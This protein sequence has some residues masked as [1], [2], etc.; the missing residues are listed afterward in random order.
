MKL[1]SFQKSAVRTVRSTMTRFISIALIS[2]LG[3]GVF[4]GLA[5]I[6]PNMRREGDAYYDRQNVMDIRMLSTYGFT[7]EDVDA[8]R[9][10]QGVS[11]VTAS[12]TTDAVGSVGDKDY[13]FRIN[14]L[15]TSQNPADPDYINQLH[16]KEGRWPE[17]A[18][19]AI[20]I[21]PAIG[22]K[23][24]TL[25][26]V[27]SIDSDSD[28][29]LPETLKGMEYTITGIAESP[30]YL[31]FM[32]GNTNVGGGMVN[33]VLYIPQENF[34][35]DGYT[36]LYVTVAGAKEL[37]TFEKKYSDCVDIT[38]KR[39]ENLAADRQT[40]RYDA[41]YADLHDAKL[42][43]ADAQQEADEKLSDSK[44]QLEDGFSS[45]NTAKD[46]YAEGE[47]EYQRQRQEAEQKLSDARIAIEEASQRITEGEK[48][49]SLKE[50]AVT[51]AVTELQKA[52][53]ELDRGW[54][55]YNGKV[56]ELA[57]SQKELAE[58]KAA[59]D[60][61]QAQYEAGLKKTGMTIEQIRD[62][63][64]SLQEQIEKTQAQYD[65]LVA[66]KALHDAAF[67]GSEDYAQYLSALQA[68]G[69]TESE[70]EALYANMDDMQEKLHEARSQYT[71][72]S[73]LNA[74]HQ[75]L[76]EKWDAYREAANQISDGEA[77][78]AAAKQSLDHKEA[79]YA[80]SEKEI[81]AAQL[82]LKTAKETL[83][84]AR[85]SYQNGLVE[86]ETQ[87]YNAQ[88][89]LN[90]AKMQLDS[91]LKE[92]QS[93]EA[94]LSEKQQEYDNKKAEVDTELADARQKI[95]DAEEKL[96]DLG[97]PKWYVLDRDMNE[98]F[99]SYSDDT[100]RMQDLATVFPCIFFLVAALVCLTTM[101]RMVDEDRNLIGTFKAL[102]YSNGKIARRYLKY[103]AS[104]SVAGSIAGV[105]FGFWLIPTIVWNAY[106]IVFV[107]PTLKPAL[108]LGIGFAAVFATVF[109]ITLSTWIA[110]KRSLSESPAELMRPKAPK[111]G[112]R[113]F[114]EYIKPV[115]KRLSFSEKVTVRN[116]LLNKK[117]LIMTL[118]GIIGCTALV[119]TAFG[120]KNAVSNIIDKQFGDI[121]HY[122]AEVGFN[123]EAPS[124]ELTDLLSNPAYIQKSAEA[125]RASAE[126]SLENSEEDASS[127]YIVSLKDDAH[128]ADYITLTDVQSNKMLKFDS[129][130]AVI[131]QKL[132]MNLNAAIGD[133]IY[134][135]Y[136]T[137]NDRHPVTVTGITENYAFNYVY[138]GSAA[139]QKVFGK[140]PVYNQLFLIGA[141]GRTD[142]EI[143]EYLSAAPDTG[144][145][146][147]TDDLMGN[148][149]TS[150]K[151]VDNIIWILIIAAG[152][153]AFVVLYNLTNI[154]IGE[155]QRELA[156]LK[157]L[158]FYDK[159]T[160][161]YIF[162][163]TIIL[164]FIGSLIGLLGGIFLYRVVV[165]TVESNIIFLTRDLK[166]FAYLGA[167][168]LTLLFT[169]VVNCCMKPK[170]KN[171]DMLESLK[172][173]E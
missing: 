89:E 53:E 134:V 126:A 117:R 93:G 56:S 69:L 164:S 118:I 74:V 99:V 101:T 132:S 29:A 104:A 100:K 168:L 27:V 138:L 62:G 85:V 83:A 119:L 3:A 165:A 81:N 139:Y 156:T 173:V 6:S 123:G 35:V 94:E 65:R 161:T 103:A 112:K 154:N 36:D 82:Q 16:I 30:Y 45:L 160:Y 148:I 18:D 43:Y 95:N 26:S 149:R 78:I 129:D 10:T 144:A 1:L 67:P 4:G 115:W 147:F 46:Q 15:S 24:I 71:Q 122:S 133:T 2:F 84:A 51:S 21:R 42:K 75:E 64:P 145:I 40:L 50:S 41:F 63:L 59:L 97:E 12:Y 113:V 11:G 88:K 128:L 80:D 98:S 166:W 32:Q 120:A 170:I 68:A 17:R 13:V 125:V 141:D 52:R 58:N 163:E 57:A 87:S 157:V 127:I 79:E 143:K 130:S 55:A 73:T 91:A 23:N 72:L 77:Q 159:E 47:S 110:A 135:K 76:T 90:K 39:L 70:A 5:A 172:S 114:M 158:G 171:I 109:I 152:L 121:F 146:S 44:N 107:L 37:N 86:Y 106:N 60:A 19:E 155:R 137:E 169:W 124:A 8:I 7:D 61:A 150:V 92:I 66:L 131:T 33:Y 136:L 102:G 48:E 38:V 20:I 142:D 14:G 28:S 49:F 140:A 34:T 22:L 167:A 116:I 54:A 25:D 111:N 9:K 108:Y 151:S 153:L 31:F 105:L 162:R 96:S